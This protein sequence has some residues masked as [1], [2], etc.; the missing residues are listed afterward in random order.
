M[1]NQDPIV[2]SHIFSKEEQVIP[3][4]K[5]MNTLIDFT[6]YCTQHPEERFWQA[7]RN[8]SEYNFIYGGKNTENLEYNSLTERKLEDTFYKE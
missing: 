4:N 6:A 8:W 7:L 3:N 5:N 1:P 2:P